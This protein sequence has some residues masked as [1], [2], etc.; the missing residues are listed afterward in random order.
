MRTE[1]K[2]RDSVRYDSIY[3]HDSIFYLIKGDT[4]Y[5][6]V[7]QVEYKYLF[8]NRTDTILKTDSIQV[9]YPVEKRLTRWQTLKMELGGWA[10][11]VIIVFALVIVGRMIYRLRKK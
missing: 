9:P 2:T 4:V 5:K 11:G 3:K 8:I 10:L 6:Y 7:K 1:Y